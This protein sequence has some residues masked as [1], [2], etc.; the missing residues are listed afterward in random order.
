MRMDQPRPQ[1][2]EIRRR[3][4]KAELLKYEAVKNA[5]GTA[6]S[7][8]DRFD[9]EVR[10]TLI[11]PATD[12]DRRQAAKTDILPTQKMGL[13]ARDDSVSI[14]Q[15]R[16]AVGQTRYTPISGAAD[17]KGRRDCPRARSRSS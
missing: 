14:H 3:R 17:I 8:Q 5:D 2:R 1:S 6:P 12:P 15:Q 16:A 11:R 7:D 9:P 4:N 10:Q 13:R